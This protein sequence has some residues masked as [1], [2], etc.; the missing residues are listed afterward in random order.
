MFA[1]D[2]LKH[3]AQAQSG[4]A[5]RDHYHVYSDIYD[6]VPPSQKLGSS[7]GQYWSVDRG[8]HQTT[9][10]SAVNKTGNI[11]VERAVSHSS[12]IVTPGQQVPPI[13]P[14]AYGLPLTPPRPSRLG[15]GEASSS[16]HS[17]S[18]PGPKSFTSFTEVPQ[19]VS[20]LTI[21]QVCSCLRLLKL[22]QFAHNFVDNQVDGRL[23]MEY[24]VEDLQ[25]LGLNKI[26]AKKLE[27]FAKKNWRPL[28]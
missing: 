2:N 27:M 13:R 19:D 9:R 22:E 28:E 15:V 3:G 16:A 24:S 21:N 12:M 25:L 1:D 4:S 17:P 23:L 20:Q 26:Q 8:A 11:S 10:G 7:D 5:L 14:H 6:N 18:T